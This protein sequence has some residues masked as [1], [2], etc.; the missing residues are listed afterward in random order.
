MVVKKSHQIESVNPSS[1]QDTQAML[2]QHNLSK[3]LC[4]TNTRYNY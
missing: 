1:S 3:N 2:T 4:D